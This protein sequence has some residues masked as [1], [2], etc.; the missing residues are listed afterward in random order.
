[1]ETFFI[2][3][4]RLQTV[5]LVQYVEVVPYHPERSSEKNLAKTTK[6]SRSIN[7]RLREN[8][9]IISSSVTLLFI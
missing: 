5:A 1:M 6:F 4:V 2:I 8:F 7:R 3:F 9:E